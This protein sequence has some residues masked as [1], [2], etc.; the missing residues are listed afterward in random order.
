MKVQ[1]INKTPLT[2]Y[3]DIDGLEET[4]DIVV[5]GPKAV[6]IVELPSEK[7]FLEISK[8]FVKKLSLRKL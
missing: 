1:I 8:Q 5:I 3:V 6:E 4:K 2:Q 7:R